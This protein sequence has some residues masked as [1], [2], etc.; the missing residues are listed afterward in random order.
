MMLLGGYLLATGNPFGNVG[1]ILGAWLGILITVLLIEYQ[2][3]SRYFRHIFTMIDELE[4]QYLLSEMI[5]ISDRQ[6]DK[7][8]REILHRSNQ[9]VIEKI[10]GIQQERKD[11]QEFIES[12]IHEVKAPMTDIRLIC[13]NLANNPVIWEKEAVGQTGKD[14]KRDEQINNE[15][16]AI[17]QSV[18]DDSKTIWSMYEGGEGCEEKRSLTEAKTKKV[19]NKEMYR[20]IIAKLSQVENY[21]DMALY[22]ARSDSV[23]QD[24][25][26]A[27][28]PLQET[29]T[30]I[31]QQ[32]KQYFMDHQVT[33][34]LQFPS[35]PDSLIVP[36]DRKWLEFIF[37]QIFLNA[38]K[39]S[40]ADGA[41]INIS[42]QVLPQSID[43]HI[44]DKGIGIPAHELPRIF[45]KGFTGSNGRTNLP[46]GAA[47]STG[48]GLYL[49]QKLCTK[50]GIT[51]TAASNVGEYTR[52]T[53][54][55]PKSDYYQNK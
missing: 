6:E 13:S 24:Y 43:I 47:K 25:L 46:L 52:I 12:W 35:E 16:K 4:E 22:Y 23:Y 31:L 27:P 30:E 28:V 45:D 8:Y 9:A 38:V 11:Y 37:N 19:N 5:P 26:I 34:E 15:G 33:A 3:R 1:L 21:V 51:I 50:M 39:Y 36:G 18:G 40:K 49:C 7:L 41:A 14:N 17:E 32:N 42:A 29:V 2:N 48:I 44:E 10:A 20:K 54:H 53:L 55:F